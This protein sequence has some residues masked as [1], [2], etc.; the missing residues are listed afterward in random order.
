MLHAEVH[1][2]PGRS[3]MLIKIGY[4]IEL[5]VRSPM[6]LIY[7]LRVHPSRRDDL[8]VP[9]A[10]RISDNLPT[11]EY[12]DGYGN[13]CG[14]V[15]IPLGIQSVRFTNTAYVRDSGEPDIVDLAAKQH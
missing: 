1:E 14:R 5:G 6:A 15:N 3:F 10:V 12:I 11:E 9:E 4:D 7:M 2:R 8:A 13:H